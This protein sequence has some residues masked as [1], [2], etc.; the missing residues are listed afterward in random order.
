[1]RLAEKLDWKGLMH[2]RTDKRIIKTRLLINFVLRTFYHV[3]DSVFFWKHK[4]FIACK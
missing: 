2:Y 1:M 4:M 3:Q